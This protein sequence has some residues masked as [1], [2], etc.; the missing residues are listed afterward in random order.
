MNK[1]EQKYQFAQKNF[2]FYFPINS[3]KKKQIFDRMAKMS[4]FFYVV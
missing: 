3:F 4:V 1:L 2:V